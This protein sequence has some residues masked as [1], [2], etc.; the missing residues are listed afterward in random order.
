V[1]FLT[2]FFLSKDA[3]QATDQGGLLADRNEP[4]KQVQEEIT[5]RGPFHPN[6]VCL[7]YRSNNEGVRGL[8]LQLHPTAFA[9]EIFQQIHPSPI[10]WT[11]LILP[12][13]LKQK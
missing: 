6:C 12:S 3:G 9:K 10:G 13:A 4:Q 7:R 11:T 8:F 5:P 2:G 1:F